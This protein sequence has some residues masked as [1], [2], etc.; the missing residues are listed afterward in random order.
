[1][2]IG[3]TGSAEPKVGN[4]LGSFSEIMETSF[5][6]N[7]VFNRIINPDFS[8]PVDLKGALLCLTIL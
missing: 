3:K 8:F 4:L 6:E 5:Q 7:W 1:M 2:L